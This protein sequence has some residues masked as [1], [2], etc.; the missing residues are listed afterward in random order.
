[1]P[2]PDGRPSSTTSTAGTDDGVLP[3]AEPVAAT[4]VGFDSCDGL[5]DYYVDGA[6]DLVGPWGLA[7][8][9]VWT[10]TDGMAAAEDTSGGSDASAASA[11]R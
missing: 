3:V 1:M 8:G 5:L 7:G 11:P 4:L 10:A 9:P 6:R 2:A